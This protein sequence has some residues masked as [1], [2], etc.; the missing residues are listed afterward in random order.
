MT[1]A[2]VTSRPGEKHMSSATANARIAQLLRSA[3]LEV[4][5]KN[6][7]NELGASLAAGTDVYV[8][9]L[10]GDDM[11]KR[12]EIAKALR[13][14]GFNPVLHVPARQMLSVDYLAEYIAV[15][16][17]AAKVNRVLLIAGD[18]TRARGPFSTSL[19]VIK[20]GV[21]QKHGIGHVDVAG[22]PEGNVG[23]SSS[24]LMRAL[25]DKR[26]AARAEGISMAVVTQFCFDP[27]PIS[28]WLKATS[29]AKLACP[30]R[31]GL[32][33]P[34]NP[35]TLM[36]FALRCGVGNS[37]SA[38]QKHVGTI[39]RLLRDTGPEGVVR[40]LAETL[41]GD[42]GEHVENFHFFPFGGLNKTTGWIADALARPSV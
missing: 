31:I 37:V 33:G 30:I 25:I 40:G 19:D 29:E 36:K 35:A 10:P 11:A 17:A 42:L 9:Y 32:A 14:G 12:V 39:G 23:L 5:S 24:D 22:H 1:V 41:N 21:L 8:S 2:N 3:T 6:A 34:A 20:S 26:D 4:Y 13:N 16:A 27:H 38:L 7:P 28:E 15:S 18:S